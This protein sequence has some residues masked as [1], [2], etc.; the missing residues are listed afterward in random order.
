MA[1]S[2]EVVIARRLIDHAKAHGFHFRRL[3]PGPDGPLWGVRETE[4]WRDSVFVGGFSNSCSATRQ[5]KS[6]LIVPGDLLVTDRISGTAL[7]V[8]NAITTWETGA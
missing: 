5:R 7:S 3:A 4:Q 8:L 2:P 6:S 1:D